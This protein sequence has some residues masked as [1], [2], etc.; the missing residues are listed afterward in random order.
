MPCKC[1]SRL[2]WPCWRA[3]GRRGTTRAVAAAALA[4]VPWVP[5]RPQTRSRSEGKRS[6]RRL[7]G[8]RPGNSV[9]MGQSRDGDSIHQRPRGKAGIMAHRSAD[10]AEV[11]PGFRRPGPCVPAEFLGACSFWGGVFLGDAI[12][13][14]KEI[15][16]PWAR[17]GRVFFRPYGTDNLRLEMPCLRIR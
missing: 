11:G 2:A 6:V 16:C 7:R 13:P 3:S 17:V 15:P 9:G 4:W 10:C 1:Q 12:C 14:L 8:S 5:A